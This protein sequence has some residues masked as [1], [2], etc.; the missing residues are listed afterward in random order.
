MPWWQ[1]WR[2]LAPGG[3]L[4]WIRLRHE[5]MVQ[6][7]LQLLLIDRLDPVDHRSQIRK[8][9]TAAGAVLPAVDVAIAP[10]VVAVIST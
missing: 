10:V 6:P 5:G 7:L 8:G 3:S 2:R 9:S 1:L 4:R